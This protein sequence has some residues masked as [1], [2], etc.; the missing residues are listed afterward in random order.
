M[1]E[2]LLTLEG[3]LAVDASVVGESRRTWLT[4]S[5]VRLGVTAKA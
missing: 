5:L 2:Q 4:D 1:L 3:S